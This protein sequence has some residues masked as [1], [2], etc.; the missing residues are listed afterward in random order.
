MSTD[1]KKLIKELTKK[2]LYGKI[3]RYK[4]C[5]F[6][7]SDGNIYQYLPMNHNRSSGPTMSYQIIGKEYLTSQCAAAAIIKGEVG[8]IQEP[9]G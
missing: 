7:Y 4:G 3:A 2:F 1:R 8:K 9:L 5:K 6:F